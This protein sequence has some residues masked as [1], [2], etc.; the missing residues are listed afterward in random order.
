VDW[1]GG[2]DAERTLTYNGT[3]FDLKH[4]LN[5]AEAL[6]E[7]G[8]RPDAVADLT[9]ALPTHVD[10]ALAARDVHEAEL[11][12]SQSVLPAWKPTSSK[13]STTRPP[14]TTTTTSTRRSSPDSVS[15]TGW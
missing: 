6:A 1:C 3:Y 12:E 2:R 10:V 8:V 14:G 5:W 9:A 4:V 13:V 15:R 11:W 7:S